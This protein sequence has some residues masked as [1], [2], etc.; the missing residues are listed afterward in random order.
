MQDSDAHPELHKALAEWY[1][2]RSDYYGQLA[3][4]HGVKAANPLCELPIPEK[5]EKCDYP[6]KRY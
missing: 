4:Y 3:S 1:Q 6:K 2:A 5:S